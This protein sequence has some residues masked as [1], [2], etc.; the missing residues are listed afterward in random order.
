M[1][2][3]MLRTNQQ[4]VREV[5]EENLLIQQDTC[6]KFL[7]ETVAL[8]W[9]ASECLK[10]YSISPDLLTEMSKKKTFLS[11]VTTDNAFKKKS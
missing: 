3:L 9:S 4:S 8:T 10:L 6:L 5:G 2:S 11:E 7:Q 1:T